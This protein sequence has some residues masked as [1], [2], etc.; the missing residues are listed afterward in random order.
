MSFSISALLLFGL[1]LAMLI[2][3]KAVGIGGALVAILFGYYLSRTGLSA[4]I[5]QVMGAIGNAIPD[6]D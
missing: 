5:D 2:R 3:S 1:L 6:L 4:P